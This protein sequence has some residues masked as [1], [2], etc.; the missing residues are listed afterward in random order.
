MDAPTMAPQKIVTS[1]AARQ[2]QQVQVVGEDA[3]ARDVGE[4]REGGGRDQGAADGQA[5]QA[6]GHVHRVGWPPTSTHHREEDVE[7]A[8]VRA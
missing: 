4:R 3:V 1:P 5:V 8:E 7:Q 2:E 6:V